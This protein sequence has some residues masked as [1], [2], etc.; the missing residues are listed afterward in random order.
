MKRLLLLVIHLYWRLIPADRRRKCIFRESCSQHVFNKT[1]EGGFVEGFKA[2]SF[3]F[4]N[5]RGNIRFFTES[6]NG[7]KLA[8]LPDGTVVEDACLSE[9]FLQ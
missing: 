9:K 5:C 8:L 4:R 6:I 3:R 7:K 2:L 1:K